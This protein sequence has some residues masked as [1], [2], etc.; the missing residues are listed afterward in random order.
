VLSVLLVVC[1]A[2]AVLHTDTDGIRRAV[3]ACA[4]ATLATALTV[5]A[6]SALDLPPHRTALAV[7]AVPVA[8][9]L[10]AARLRTLRLA[11]PLETAGALAATLAVGLS[12]GHAPSLALTLALT[13]VIAAGTALRPERRPVSY[14]AGALLAAA[15]WVR[16]AAWDVTAPEAYTL[17][18]TLPALAVGVLRRRREPDTSS[19]A[20]YAPG[21]AVTLLPSLIAAWSDPHWLRPLL[22]GAASLALTLLGARHRLQAPLALG[23]TVLALV[24]A[25]ELAP[26]VVQ[27]VGALPRWLPP[28][29]AGLLLLAVGATYE[30]RLRDARRLRDALGRMH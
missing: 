16:L 30:Q 18:V 21:L 26:Y 1:V 11:V 2:A 7:L 9:A 6:P 13:G 8:T 20:A 22:L 10:L 24:A 17:P 28:A 15:C 23:G 12:V 14:A 5:A 25:H 27:V 3:A 29:L 19:W 4:A